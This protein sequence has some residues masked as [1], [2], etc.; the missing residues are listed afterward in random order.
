MSGLDLLIRNGT[1]VTMDD[2]RRITSG[3]VRI[4]GRR[5]TAVGSAPQVQSAGKVLDATGCAV[6]P[7]L[8][9]THVHLCQTLFRGLADGLELLPWLRTR[10]W[11]FEA[12]HDAASLRASADLGLA[13][14]LLAGTTTILDM[15]TVHAHDA[16]FEAMRDAGIRGASGKA[17][18]DRGRG[19]PG[20]LRESTAESLRES[21]RLLSRWHGVDDGR[22]RY[23][24]APRFV[25]SCS[26]RLLRDVAERADAAGVLVHTHAAENPSEREAVKSALG[27]DDIEALARAGIAGP[28]A[29]LAH[30]VH[31][32]RTE[33]RRMAR[34]GT[35]VTHCPSAN[36]KLASGIANV[37]AMR[38]AGL[39]VGLG[40]DGAACND[41][42]DPW[43]EMRLASL[44]SRVRTNRPDALL[45]DDVLAMATRDGARVLGLEHEIGTL[46]VGK[47]ADVIV[48]R[49]NRPHALPDVADPV[50]RLVYA[51]TAAD[52]RH[53]VIDGRVIVEEGRLRTIDVSRIE[54]EARRALVALLAR[55]GLEHVS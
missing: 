8:V 6:L 15:G 45:A 25:L 48:V 30:G 5:L 44:L 18:M 23:A 33:M 47:R 36:M 50:G 54:E 17:M 52:V 34:L 40:A 55:A 29:V 37:A 32:R 20:P 11:P 13:E 1:I 10:I 53:V 38:A 51:C 27:V 42:L 35:R 26:E 39:V 16:V 2:A 24:F 41:R 31:L 4:G 12:A 43:T 28:K 49:M 46:E 21:E 9:Q 22:L 14:L 19:R 3:D 7:G